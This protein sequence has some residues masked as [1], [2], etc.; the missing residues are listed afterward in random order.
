[1]V[2]LLV[3][4]LLMSNLLTYRATR[5]AYRWRKDF[6][7]P[8]TNI[9]SQNKDAEREELK[10][11]L[12]V[13]DILSKRHLE[14]VSVDELVQAAIKGMVESLDDPQTAFL[15]PTHY[16]EM[17]IRIDGSFSGIGIE[18]NSVD[19][20]IT[21]IAPIKN[22]PG[23]RAGLLAGDRITH[24]DG[25]D[26]IGIST[27]EAVKLMRGPEGTRVVL[28][29]ERDGVA[30]PLTFD[31]TRGNVLLP[32]VSHKMMD[33]KIGYVEISKFDE[34]T[35]DDFKTALLEL[36]TQ[37]MR[38]LI[39]DLRD[40]PGGLLDQAVK[41]GQEIIPAGPITHMVDRE[42]KIVQTFPSYGS[43]KPYPLVVLVNGSSASASEIIA[44]AVQDTGV[45]V[46]V[47]TKTY[48]K[49]TVQ[50]VESLQNSGGL[51]YTVAKYQTPKGRDIHGV[52]L[53]P[54]ITVELPDE[55]FMVH[56]RLV[57]DVKPG[58]EGASV[59]FLQKM[60][61][62]LKYNLSETGKYDSKTEQAV[63]AFQAK[64]GLPVTGTVNKAVRD[65]LDEEINSYLEKI[66]T[67]MKKAVEILKEKM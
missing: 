20:Y 9:P 4:L 65:K 30:E 60:L 42:G 17:M 2:P 51:Q 33:N 16:E 67:Q 54:D 21:I 43:Q 3:V 52:G 15:D 27:M 34:H 12:Q 8:A 6:T 22:T 26:I 48:G 10:P 7:H 18:I 53:E 66:D 11:F 28:T 49:A 24:V 44:G 39:I 13:L 45:G 59:M 31:I 36:E 23:E 46:L 14:E 47:G 55:F 32:S 58:D 63:R 19:D 25:K 62:T 41:I 5:A 35:S 1:M 37:G 29:V 38:G 64:H 57:N 50:H 61:M 56:H 40:N